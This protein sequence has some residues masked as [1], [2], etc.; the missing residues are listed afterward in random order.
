MI[1]EGGEPLWAV[2]A[3]KRDAI[4]RAWL[5]ETLR[6]YAEQTARFLL[7][8]TD[9]FRNPVGHA[10]GQA[11]PALYDALLDRTD[12]A[13]IAPLL[14]GIVRIRAVQ[15]FSPS[16][17]VAFIFRLKPVIRAALQE[18]TEAMADTDGLASVEARIDEMALLAFDLFVQ[19]REQISEIKA[20][21]ARRRTFVKDRMVFARAAKKPG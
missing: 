21:D 2:L 13:G 7:Q 1:A 4:V 9:P 11:L 12:A 8:E 10:L 19:C 3:S 5:A 6:T 17:A 14:D 15:D 16:Q 20:S 18:D